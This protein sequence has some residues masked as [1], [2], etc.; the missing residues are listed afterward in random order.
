MLNESQKKTGKKCQYHGNLTIDQIYISH[1]GYMLCLLCKQKK[2]STTNIQKIIFKELKCNRCNEIKLIDFFYKNSTPKN[3]ECKECNKK[4]R[5]EYRQ[6]SCTK[7]K[8]Y[9]SHLIRFY[10]RKYGITLDDYNSMLKEQNGLCAI[11]RMP[12]T[13][14]DKRSN[15]VQRLNVDHC[16]KTGKVRGLLCIKC[17]HGIGYFN[18]NILLLE[19]CIRYLQHGF[20][21]DKY[22][23][24]EDR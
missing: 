7:E 13:K 10:K 11:C 23:Q 4:R 8:E 19:S 22:I 14:I 15:K 3:A 5:K 21:S 6:K 16:H 17:N 12:S 9:I 24:H 2:Q 20:I 18:D 1:T